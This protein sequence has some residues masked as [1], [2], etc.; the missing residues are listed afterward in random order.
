MN[1]SKWP[2]TLTLIRHAPSAY[3]MMKGERDKTSLYQEFLR[4]S[5]RNDSNRSEILRG[6]ARQV[7]ENFAL[8]VSDFSTPLHPDGSADNRRRD[9]FRAA[10][11][12]WQDEQHRA[13][14]LYGSGTK[15]VS[16]RAHGQ[17]KI[18]CIQRVPSS[19]RP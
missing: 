18:I 6:L 19:Q 7:E 4:E 17:S 10:Q 12:E 13:W 5:N 14:D 3:N 16:E 15:P 8:K 9:G 2:E 11:H 1:T